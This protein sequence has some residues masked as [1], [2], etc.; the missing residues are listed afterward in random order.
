MN[1]EASSEGH[2]IAIPIQEEMRRSYLT[3]AM[4]TIISRALPDVRD[5]LKPSQRRILVA[6]NDLRL[7]PTASRVKCAKI[8]GDT[9]GNY[10]PHGD[11]AIYPT[12]VRLAQNWVMREVLIDK[13][14]NFGSLAG[15]PP[16]AMRYTE[17]RLS[18]AAAEM[19]D[20]LNHDTVDFVPT[21]DN[22]RR[23]P[24]VLPS[25]FPNLLVN[26]C[27]G[28]AVGMATSIPPHNTAEVCDALIRLLDDPDATLDDLLEVLPGPDFPTGGIIC[29]RQ[30]IREAYLTGRAQITLRARAEILQSKGHEIIEITEIPYNQTRDN[31]REE[32]ERL[33][34]DR[35][36]TE[37]RRNG[38]DGT[39]RDRKQKIE[40]RVQGVARVVDL[41][42]RTLPSW[43]VRLHI[44]LKQGAD[45]ETVLKQ[46]Y[47]HSSL[48]TRFSI[49]LLALVGN[50]PKLLTLKE[51][52]QEFL[53]HR[54]TVVRRRTEY[55]LAE[56]RKRK[57]TVEGLLIALVDLDKVIQTIRESP[58]RNEAKQR[59]Q[60]IPVP[61]P[62]AERALGHDSFQL[63]VRE[64]GTREEYFLS[65][66]QAEA[67]VSMQLGSLAN[68]EQE[69]LREEDRRLY[70]EIRRHLE[71]LSDESQLRAAV[72]E[73]LMQ[74][75]EKYRDPRRTDISDDELQQY[76]RE[77][78]VPEEPMVVTLSQHGYIKRM[79][80]N[81]YQA[82]H[83]GGKG[84]KAAT[85][86]EDDELAHL[87]V[88]S[89]HDWMLF[90]TNTGRV[91]RLKVYD[92]PTGS[93]DSKGRMVVNVLSLQ[94]EEKVVNM[95][96]TRD[97]SSGRYLM[98]AT[99]RGI[100]KKT[101]LSEYA[102]VKS[103]GIIAIELRENDTLVQAL[104]VSP[105]EDV[106]LATERGMAI[107]FAESAVRPM[108]RSAAGVRG[109]RLH[110]DDAVI[111]M[112]VADPK[113]SL[114]TICEHGYGKRTPFGNGGEAT[115]GNSSHESAEDTLPDD[116]D[117]EDTLQDVEANLNHEEE[118]EGDENDASHR[119]YRRQNRGGK[120][121]R[122]IRT[123]ERNGRA[124]KI[125]AVAE[126]D[127]VLVISAQGKIQ[128]L[129]VDSIS[130]IGRNTQGVRLMR[131][132][133]GDKI[134]SLAR[135]PASLLQDQENE[136]TEST[137]SIM[138]TEQ[139]PRETDNEDMVSNPAEIE[140]TR[141]A[142][143]DMLD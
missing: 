59:L 117:S 41:T 90:F 43:R 61:A 66:N 30:G 132:D 56:A 32:L 50:R 89:T 97:F 25:R 92:L 123:T 58:N 42:D 35:T 9:N 121:I 127:E 129:R 69:K 20:D 4:S 13:Q 12:L 17:A 102:H 105:G 27:N 111:G 65:A 107:R 108:G 96:A 106:L 126:G 34:R 24:V 134:A 136:Q 33:I 51:M 114:L 44:V 88:A 10:H 7:A 115:E 100:V 49:I 19:L 128:R 77:A 93:R 70:A 11:Q 54:I 116:L 14:G 141:D 8:V 133:D 55:L 110:P 142:P 109:I 18:T 135:I 78:L 5:G 16:A 94:P 124:V 79:P 113:E 26:G 120:G 63:L 84:I 125:A 46:L 29:G 39:G 40:A 57:H 75:K 47:Q 99:R 21:Y 140:E 137:E 3:Y 2:I 64:Q 122:D 38:K 112:V 68:L 37:A 23:E 91:F 130:L 72:R 45:A 143:S 62:L 22:S 138:L 119:S 60:A 83:R 82:Q 103:T 52:L 74:L 86:R 139:P 6:M 53:R 104:I 80:L 73:E 67:I 95:A 36:V 85:T 31:I 101:E 118:S 81:T 48:Q 71:L 15:L 98:F 76:D 1:R 131:L 87:C 28:I